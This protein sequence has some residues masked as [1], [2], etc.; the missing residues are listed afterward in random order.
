MSKF[1]V[2]FNIILVENFAS[3]SSPHS[4]HLYLE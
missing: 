3:L 1:I 2:I 4:F